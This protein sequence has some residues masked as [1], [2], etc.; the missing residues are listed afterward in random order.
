MKKSYDV[1]IIGGG[2]SGISCALNLLLNGINNIL[3][4][5]KYKFPRYKCCAGYIT[6]KTKKAYEQLGL[7]IDKCNYSLIKDFNICYK[8]NIV[9]RIDNKFLYTNKN[10]NRVELDNNFVK[11]AKEKGIEIKEESSIT[12]HNID[13]NEITI[14]NKERV[15][16]NYLIFADG[17]L[18]F[19]SRYQK[20]KNKNIAM[21]AIIKT[22]T[23]EKIDIH[24]G[25]SKKGYGWISSYNKVTNIGLTDVY[26]N[27]INYIEL[28]KNYAKS[29]NIKIND[30][31][32]KGAFTPIGIR[33]PIIN[34]TIF[35]VGD[36]LGACDPLTLSGLRYSL[37]S[38]EICAKA[39]AKNNNKIYYKYV[40]IL[41][42]KFSIMKIILKI[43]YLKPVLFIIFNIGSR[44]FG[45]FIAKMFNNFF[46]NKK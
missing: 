32:I 5:E 13:K 14:N 2:P 22:N 3:V 9:Q 46:I 33:K 24:F 23:K 11:I 6:G 34:N 10:I 44:Y 30:K 15:K 25:I 19:G 1:V 4:I 16:Y 26:D 39:I 40:L 43:F 8:L 17:T 21:Q 41:R 20:T 37:K 36:A 35:Y 38:G 18:G 27:D 7:N 45:N 12:N 29:M 28:F 42:I 31:D